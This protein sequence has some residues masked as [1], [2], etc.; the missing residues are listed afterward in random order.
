MLTTLHYADNLDN[1]EQQGLSRGLQAEDLPVD[2]DVYA[3]QGYDAAQLLGVGLAA[4]NG[5]VGE[6]DEMIAA[7]G[8][9][10]DRQPARHVHAVEGAQPGAGHLP[11]RG[12]QRPQRV[13]LG[14]ARKALADPARGCKHVGVMR[15]YARCHPGS[16]EAA[17]RDP[18][19]AE[20]WIPGSR[21]RR[22][23]DDSALFETPMDLVTSRPVPERRAVRAAAVPGRERAD[24]DLRHP[25]RHQSRPRRLLHARRVPRLFALAPIP[26][27]SGLR[28]RAASRSPSRSGSCSRRSSSSV[29]MTATTCS[30][31]CSPTG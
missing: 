22:A 15:T 18:R 20:P 4:V 3:V 1:P 27:A 21:R 11:A 12:A 26:A 13:R 17:I 29:S 30:R 8:R 19:L 23:R 2:G 25:R 5:D 31:C 14:R 9:R 6:R 10:E 16:R 7:H 24:A 28:S